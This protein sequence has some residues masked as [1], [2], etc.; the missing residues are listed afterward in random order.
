MEFQSLCD[1][2]QELDIS[3]LDKVVLAFYT[4]LGPE[5]QAAQT[6]LTQF[7]ENPDAWTRVPDILQKS[8]YPQTKYI[9]LQILEKLIATR[10][11]S[12]PDGQRQ[13]VRNFLITVTV[14]VA[15]DEVS[16]RKQKVYLNKLNLAMVQVLKQEWPHRWPNFISELVESSKSSIA[17]CTNNMVLLRLLS[18]ELFDF[19]A[20]QM[21]QAKA[22]EL[23]LQLSNELSQVFQLCLEVLKEAGKVTLLKATLET[24]SRFLSWMPLGYIFETELLQLLVDR[25]LE[26]AEY[27]NITLRCAAEIANLPR[28]DVAVYDAPFKMFFTSVMTTVNKLIPPSTDIALAYANASD[29]GQEMVVALAMFLANFFSKHLQIMEGDVDREA[30]LN[31]HFYLIKISQVEEREV[32]KICLE[33]WLVLLVGLYEEVSRV[34]LG[35][36]FSTLKLRK[37]IYKDVLTNLRLVGVGKMVKPEEVLVVENEEGEVVRE[38]LQEVDSIALYKMMRELM[39]YLTHLDVADMET[40]L[41]EKMEAQIDGAEWS[42]Q[43]L[44]TL[45]WAIGSISGAMDEEM[46][47]RF[48]VLVIRELLGLVEQKRGQGQQGDYCLQYHTVANKLFEFMHET[49]EGVQDMACDTYMKIAQQCGRQFVMRQ[50]DEK[51]PFIDEIL[52]TVNRITV[53]LSPQQ[54]QTFYEATGVIIAEAVN[55]AQQEKLI[56]ALM[57]MPN[58][59][60]DALMMQ[61]SVNP[62]LLQNPESVKLLS[63]VLKTNVSA[64]TSIG[65]EAYTPQIARIFTDMLGLYKAISGMISEIIAKEGILMSKTPKVRQLRAV[66]KDIL[67]LLQTYISSVVQIETVNDNFIPPLLDAVLGDYQRNIA[68]SRDAEVLNLMSEV[69]KSLGSLI[70]PQVLPILNA[71]LEPT[72]EMITQDLT[73]YPDHRLYFFR[74]LRMIILSCFPALLSIPPEGFKLV[75][76]S[77][78]WAVKHSARDLGDTGLHMCLEILDAFS[79]SSPQVAQAFYQQYFLTIV[80]EVFYVMTDS[81]H[82]SGF[83]LQASVLSRMFKIVN[84]G[85]VPTSVLDPS[86]DP[87]MSSGDFF[88]GYCAKLLSG[89]FPH[90]HASHIQTL[91]SGMNENY[92]DVNRFKAGLKDFLVQMKEFSADEEVS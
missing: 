11:K 50:S 17:L 32:F 90:V 47:K 30:L 67:K 91:V 31:A 54:V 9:G 21:T 20:D 38:H 71:V 43:N 46:E 37:D 2:S 79:S 87:S 83:S 75:M 89:A 86:A 82:K 69:V 15:S 92:D 63:N 53:D 65:G 18:E 42:W 25:F 52:R 19:S 81:E 51:E 88:Q 28:S 29:A 59:A 13:G 22:R 12:L 4:G 41:T 74:L 49:H 23:K 3:L 33:Y 80:Q 7:Q 77:I 35:A 10:W 27:R 70:T 58:N 14:Q 45:C 73:E 16:A 6:V 36:D 24:L 66:K 39:L 55:K 62:M 72:L 44:N 85:G 60:W 34:P 57:D 5:Q 26:D 61:A 8:S 40:I 48:L 68:P 56:A 78:L 64:C 1:F 84:Q 76:D